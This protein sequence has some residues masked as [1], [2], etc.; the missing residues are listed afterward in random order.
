MQLHLLDATF[1][2]F[3]AYYGAPSRT[4]PDGQEVGAVYG[5]ILS[6][7]PLFEEG[8]VTHLGAATDQV[9]ESFRNQLYPGYKTGEGVPSDLLGQF[10]IAEDA[11]RAIGVV[12]W[13]MVD[14]EADDALATAVTRFM[15]EVERVVILS[16][17]KD[18]A[19][20]VI[21]ERVVTFDRM[22]GT[23]RG[24]EGVIAKF[25]VAP[26]SIPD[27]LALVGDSADGFPGIPGWGAKS[28]AGVLAHYLH[29]EAIPE[30]AS[31]WQVTVRGAARLAASLQAERTQALLYRELATLRRDAPIPETLTDLEWRGVPR[32][33]FEL[34][35]GE[36]GFEGLL[37]RPQ[38]W[39][40]S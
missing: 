29:L 15:D 5:L 9:I 36:L 39:Q 26:E 23:L 13:P 22:R 7:L 40:E 31:D 18:L 3:R 2:L 20:C 30:A 34:L 28:A 1:E 25:G 17:D 16:P 32:P 27:Y 6:T 21:E 37:G 14:F 19:Q 11:L 4:A 35:C 12:V 33:A 38:R 24:R 8:G 10:P